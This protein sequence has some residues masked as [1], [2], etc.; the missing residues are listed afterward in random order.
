[1]IRTRRSD[2]G[3]TGPPSKPHTSRHSRSETGIQFVC[4]PA[5]VQL[6]RSKAEWLDSGLSNAKLET[7]FNHYKTA[8]CRSCKLDR[9]NTMSCSISP[10]NQ[11]MIIGVLEYH[12]VDIMAFENPSLPREGAHLPAVRV[13]ARIAVVD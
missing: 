3:R 11:A 13:A 1:M 6:R 9:N 8:P 7:P 10:T 2:T 5:S 12:W 4:R